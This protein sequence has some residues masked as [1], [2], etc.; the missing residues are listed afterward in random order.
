MIFIHNSHTG[1]FSSLENKTFIIQVHH[2][3]KPS[4]FP[5]YKHWYESSPSSI[6]NNTSIIHMY[7]IVL[8]GFFANLSPSEAHKL[9][10]LSHAITL[11]PKQVCSLHIMHSP[12]FLDVT[13]AYKTKL[14]HETDFGPFVWICGVWYSDFR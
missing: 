12:K 3:T 5:T 7:D 8:H 2:E 1:S 13:I 9:Q 11:L 10:S 4:I 6:S 14:L